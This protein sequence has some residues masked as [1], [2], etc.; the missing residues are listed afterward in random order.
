MKNKKVVTTCNDCKWNCEN[1]D[2]KTKFPGDSF[3]QSI[4]R[5]IQISLLETNFR[6]R[7]IVVTRLRIIRQAVN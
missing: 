7:K 6:R 1:I 5:S 4:F 3:Q 2:I